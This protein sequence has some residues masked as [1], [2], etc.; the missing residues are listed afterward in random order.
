ML[1]SQSLAHLL[2]KEKKNLTKPLK[3]HLIE[4]EVFTVRE[5]HIGGIY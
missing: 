4:F 3:D 5:L 1:Q 2:L